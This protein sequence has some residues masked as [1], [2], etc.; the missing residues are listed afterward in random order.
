MSSSVCPLPKSRK[1]RK[2]LETTGSVRESQIERRG[3]GREGEREP[4]RESKGEISRGGKREGG[5]RREKERGE[6]GRG[7]ERREKERERGRV[8]SR[9]SILPREREPLWRGR[10]GVF[11]SFRQRWYYNPYK[12]RGE[13][14]LERLKRFREPLDKWHIKR[15]ILCQWWSIPFL[16]SKL[17]RQCTSAAQHWVCARS[18]PLPLYLPLTPSLS[19]S[20]FVLGTSLLSFSLSITTHSFLPPF[21]THSL[22][23][24]LLPF[25]SPLESLALILVAPLLPRIAAA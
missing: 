19:L 5:M 22:P 18:L 7:R 21:L 17:K 12:G 2:H 16:N 11:F 25:P 23:P 8:L 10:E 24:S 13:Q 9:H 15:H 3:G 6:R 14:V 4:E 1:R 20:F